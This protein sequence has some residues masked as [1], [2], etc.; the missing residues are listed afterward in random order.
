MDIYLLKDGR[1]EGP[2]RVFQVKER[3]DRGEATEADLGWHQ[4]M[5][6]W[7]PLSEIDL[8]STMLRKAAPTP[9]PVGEGGGGG[10]PE[11]PVFQDPGVPPPLPAGMVVMRV[12]VFP[13]RRLVARMFDASLSYVVMAGAITLAG[14]WTTGEFLMPTDVMR[15]VLIVA[16]ALV[17]AWLV[18]TWGT[19]PG[20]WLL[21]LGV[22]RVDGSLPH[23]GDALLRAIIGW[24]VG[25]GLGILPFTL[26]G[27]MVWYIH[28]RKTGMAWWD[29]G[30]NIMVT[31]EPLRAGR[32]IACALFFPAYWLLTLSLAM[33]ARMPDY[34]PQP[35]LRGKTLP[36]AFGEEWNRVL[37]EQNETQRRLKQNPA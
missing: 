8:L 3:L 14:G 20:K 27:W 16:W 13:W 36:E 4:G 15:L 37:R 34:V 25:W 32:A 35:S 10:V 29:L 7:R 19:T 21:G 31:M 12:P 26:I 5:E 9:E 33:T 30:R 18:M 6:A 11:R 28:Y 2:F 17:E 22:R 1:R 23:L 24:T